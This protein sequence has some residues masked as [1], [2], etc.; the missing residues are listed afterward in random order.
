MCTF[1]RDNI[2][3]CARFAFTLELNAGDKHRLS[4]PR[5][6][7][8]TAYKTRDQPL[9]RTPRSI[10]SVSFLTAVR[11]AKSLWVAFPGQL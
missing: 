5:I 9:K 8:A 10:Q 2:L 3:Y 11:L 1:V 4:S 7:V 6:L